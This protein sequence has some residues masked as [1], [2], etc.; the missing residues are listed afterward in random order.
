VLIVVCSG[1]AAGF[2]AV[3]SVFGLLATSAGHSFAARAILSIA[4]RAFRGHL[5]LEAAQV[6]PDGTFH[7][8]GARILGTNGK[9]IVTAREIR[10]RI[11]LDRLLRQEVRIHDLVLEG[12]ALR[13]SQASD[14]SLDLVDAVS[15]PRV[16]VPS[17]VAESSPGWR[18][19]IDVLQLGAERF[20]YLTPSGTL[21]DVRNCS[22]EGGKFELHRDG[23]IGIRSRIDEA[24]LRVPLAFRGS[25]EADLHI[26]QG[27]LGGTARVH[28]L[29]PD[30]AT[31]V[32]GI[33][34]VGD[35]L[36]IQLQTHDLDLSELEPA[37]P[38]SQL[39]LT[40]SASGTFRSAK[41]LD[42]S[43]AVEARDSSIVDFPFTATIHADVSEAQGKGALRVD[44][45]TVGVPGASLALSG[46]ITPTYADARARLV[47]HDARKLTRAPP[48]AIS[49][50][51]AGRAKLELTATGPPLSPSVTTHVSTP[52]LKVA[53]VDSGSA[54]LTLRFAVAPR[55]QGLNLDEL[56]LALSSRAWTLQ[57]PVTIDWRSGLHVPPVDLASGTQ[58]IRVE[59]SFTR[60]QADAAIE[61]HRLDL[62]TLPLVRP[63]L[64]VTGLVDAGL[65]YHRQKGHETLHGTLHLEN[66]DIRGIAIDSASSEVNVEGG[67]IAGTL[68][69]RS[70]LGSAHG[71]FA[72]PAEWP[73]RKASP[74]SAT[75][76]VH[77]AALDALRPPETSVLK[78]EMDLA[79]QISGSTRSPEIVMR[80]HAPRLHG[81]WIRAE[82]E[83]DELAFEA[84][85]DHQL[86][87]EL[88]L[89]SPLTRQQI[90]HA[91][92][93]LALSSADSVGQ[94]LRGIVSLATIGT[95]LAHAPM[96]LV[97][98]TPPIDVGW[99]SGRAGSPKGLFSGSLVLNAT[100]DGS[101]AKPRGHLELTGER[102]QIGTHDLGALALE[103]VASNAA[104]HLTATLHPV[105]GRLDVDARLT[106]PLETALGRRSAR[107]LPV[108]GQLVLSDLP[109]NAIIGLPPGYQGRLTG[110][111]ELR[112]SLADP[113]IQANLYLRDASW[114]EK[115]LGEAS[116]NLRL[117]G[118]GVHA[119]LSATQPTGGS[120]DGD[121]DFPFVGDEHGER[122]LS[123]TLSAQSIDLSPLQGVAHAIRQLEGIFD[124]RLQVSGT[125]RAPTL[126]GAFSVNEGSLSVAGFGLFNDVVISGQAAENAL[127]L[128]RFTLRSGSGT[129]SVSGTLTRAPVGFDLLGHLSSNRFAVYVADRLL[130]SVTTE[131]DFSGA[132]G[133]GKNETEIQVRSAEITIPSLSDTSLAPVELNSD[134]VLTKEALAPKK[135]IEHPLTLHVLAPGPLTLMGPDVHLMANADLWARFEP[136]LELRGLVIVTSGGIGLFG[137][138]FTVSRAKAEF[139]DPGRG[140]FGPPDE[141]LVTAS[142]S[143]QASGTEITAKVD[144]RWPTPTITFSSEP[145][146]SQDRII[147]LLLGGAPDTG[148]QQS[149]ALSPLTSLLVNQ[150]MGSSMPLDVMSVSASHVEAGKQLNSQLYLS[151]AYNNDPD[152]RANQFEARL[153]YRLGKSWTIDGKYGNSG[154]GAVNIEWRTDW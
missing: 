106:E 126:T 89:S 100:A 138:T 44:D 107:E 81:P 61:A 47:V 2:L 66:G 15:P 114:N 154:A 19:E 20:E 22:L 1:L 45:G 23:T 40:A 90:L 82:N 79:F 76:F 95:Q 10:G 70:P 16:S 37:L 119:K 9:P 5:D 73:A 121:I 84:R 140:T 53:G 31:M 102:L 124:A 104:V 67:R 105:Q 38:K 85:W 26:A 103:L 51:I 131:S 42:L 48:L 101:L 153:S 99:V 129:A 57:A 118:T 68:D 115:A 135:P 152:P 120:I 36:S 60:T 98:A 150:A 127:T 132:L 17:T 130:A 13:L 128:E 78:G 41:D 30:A 80:G 74:L 8:R 34:L 43:I 136:M 69:A 147:T 116:L 71:E 4:N 35:R 65:A 109:V 32:A 25:G 144:G 112:G 6:L 54:D 63:A 12:G 96:E 111:A 97:V 75:L 52:G 39:T 148:T 151:G 58:T 18:V 24:T 125:L 59:G 55:F 29:E 122:R 77:L 46:E 49:A 64:R 28:T 117:W 142:A 72:L 145:P 56:K 133:D 21:V 86:T 83:F 134:I 3:T 11:D 27:V 141:P 149:A 92:G 88:E 62:E 33:E 143:Q 93:S 110:S 108:S 50:P 146:M 7:I 139:G 137:R 91:T 94:A 123:G 87:A 14:G 113:R